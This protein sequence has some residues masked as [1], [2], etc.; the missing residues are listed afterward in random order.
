MEENWRDALRGEGD[1]GKSR[2]RDVSRKADVRRPALR[3][4]G[5]PRA[6]GNIRD[7]DDGTKPGRSH[8]IA[9]DPLDKI[10]DV[11]ARFL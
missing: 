3:L 4:K 5:R 6:R 9:F 2:G 10:E 11:Q 8:P 7:V 1:L